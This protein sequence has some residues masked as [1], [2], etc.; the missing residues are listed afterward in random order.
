MP[1]LDIH[2][3]HTDDTPEVR[4]D[5]NSGTLNIQG[6]SFPENAFAFYKP[7]LQWVKEYVEDHPRSRLTVNIDLDYFNSSSGRFILEM[8]T[9]LERQHKKELFRVNWMVEANDELMT[10]RGQELDS[11]IDLPFF[12][13][14]R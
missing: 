6:R 2:I 11:L 8:L 14:S 13:I 9:I 3:G 12:I 1:L 10:E 7:V 4:S 5:V